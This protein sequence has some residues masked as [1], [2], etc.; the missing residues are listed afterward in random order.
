[1]LELYEQ[2][3]SLIS[4]LVSSYLFGCF[5]AYLFCVGMIVFERKKIKLKYFFLLS[6]KKIFVHG[7][8]DNIPDLLVF[9]V[10]IAFSWAVP[11]ITT[12]ILLL[13]AIY[14]ACIA[15]IKYIQNNKIFN[16]VIWEI[17]EKKGKEK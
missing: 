11:A 9:C 7:D 12:L 14:V 16:V 17:K 4:S 3:M 1:M 6:E 10:M 2:S 8:D 13:M 15:L 5:V